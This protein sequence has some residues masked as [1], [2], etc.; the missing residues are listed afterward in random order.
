MPGPLIVSLSGQSLSPKE[1]I[2]LSHSKV[3]GVVLFREN[4]DREADPKTAVEKL[5]LLV[6][7]I[8]ACN[9]DLLIMVDHEGGKVWRFEPGFTKLPPAKELGELYDKNKE[10]A[11]EKAYEW[12][13]K[14]AEELRDCDIDMSLAPV[15]DLHSEKSRVIG[16]LSRAF[17]SDP[18]VV[19][20]IAE[21]FMRGMN[22][23][24]MPATLKHF[25]GHGSCSAD[26]HV[27]KKTVDG[28]SREELQKDLYPFKALCAKSDLSFAIMPAHVFYP[29][30]DQ[31]NT[32]GFSKI[33][34]QDCLRKECGFK[35]AVMSDCLLM[36]GADVGSVLERIEAAQTAGCD[37]QM[38][39]HQHGDDLDKLISLLDKI[40][41]TKEAA[42]RRKALVQCLKKSAEH[43]KMLNQ[44]E[45]VK[46]AQAQGAVPKQER[47]LEAGQG[48]ASGE[49]PDS[50][51]E[52]STKKSKAFVS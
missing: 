44:F 42:E 29:A 1:K 38:Y 51:S 36:K 21:Q 8:R 10:G 31:D 37:F 46:L 9:P 12:G 47:Q 32:A 2:L 30:V 16:K 45:R 27:T 49:K 26:S 50:E 19:A 24:G 7:E 20:E 22:S 28:R 17:H 34:L 41:D 25:P 33:W 4:Y 43:P 18:K 48:Q 3:G 15:V 5:K 13:A 14:V 11:L 40:T 52:A 23:K 6:K 39:T 35:G